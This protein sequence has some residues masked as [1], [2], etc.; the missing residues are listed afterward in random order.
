MS[1]EALKE[2]GDSPL[3]SDIFDSKKGSISCIHALSFYFF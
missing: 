1:L 3:F 2:V